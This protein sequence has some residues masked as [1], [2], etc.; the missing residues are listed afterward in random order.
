M[1]SSPT[2]ESSIQDSVLTRTVRIVEAFTAERPVL[3]VTDIA[4]RTGLH[5]ATVSR[6]VAELVRH[7]L[8]VRD[9]DRRVR[10]G[11][12]LW[13]LATRASPALSLRDAAMPLLED[14]HAV[15]GQHVQLG[16]LDGSEV[17]F[18]ERL[19]APGAAI[20]Y[21][22]IAGRVPLHSSSAGL[23]LLAHA[24]RELQEQIITAPMARYTAATIS[25]PHQLR[26]ALAEVRRVGHAACAGHIHPETLGVSVPVR[27]AHREVVAALAVIL[28]IEADGRG[29][30]SILQVAARGVERRL[31]H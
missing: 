31:S 28:P 3:R 13:E 16:V 21:T 25:S 22:R 4:E 6:L 2:N 23:V 8:L 26:R 5:L 27:D 14:L 7:G 10:I 30:V 11:M 1:A 12:R 17:L 24:P 19:S 29:V 15:I 9:P 18:L 20:N